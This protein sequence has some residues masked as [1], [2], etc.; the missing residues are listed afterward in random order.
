MGSL[1]LDSS[2]TFHLDGSLSYKLFSCLA[3][4][5]S[6]TS[7]SVLLE[8]SLRSSVLVLKSDLFVGDV[9]SRDGKKMLSCVVC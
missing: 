1:A 2:G 4:G 5:L 8:L 7:W 3:E 6:A 9:L